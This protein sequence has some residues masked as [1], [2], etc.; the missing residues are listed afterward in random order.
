MTP[1]TAP[2]CPSRPRRQAY[3]HKSR[4]GSGTPLPLHLPCAR[5]NAR[6]FLAKRASAFFASATFLASFELFKKA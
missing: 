6:Y 4:R 5:R 1:Q 2:P 3:P